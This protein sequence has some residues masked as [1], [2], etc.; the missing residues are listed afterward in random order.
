MLR[1]GIAR[2]KASL[3]TSKPADDARGGGKAGG[4]GGR[5]RKEETEAKRLSGLDLL[6][7]EGAG[8]ANL[9]E[10]CLELHEG[11]SHAVYS[12]G[13]CYNSSAF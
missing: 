3:E 9:A 7:G 11:V 2:A 1:E 5:R 12:G 10:T 13:G 6:G 4:R 8:F